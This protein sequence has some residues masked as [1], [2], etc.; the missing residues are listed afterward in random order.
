[1]AKQFNQKLKLLYLQRILLE[2]TDEQHPMT[3]P[4]LIGELLRYGIAAERKSVYA[5]LEALEQFG[6]DIA[7]EPGRNGGY[8][9]A[10]RLFEMPELK[11][12]VDAVQSSK[13][14]TVKKSNELIHKLEGFSSRYQAQQLQRQ[15]YVAN[16]VKSINE[17]V[18]YNIDR[19]HEGIA[20]NSRIS[21]QYYEY[22]V[23]KQRVY[24]RNGARYQVSPWAL[25]WDDENYYL[26][27]YDPAA[28]DIRHYRVDKMA[29]IELEEGPRDGQE[30]FEQLDMAVY[31]R[32]TFGMFGGEVCR[33]KL[34]FSNRL[35]GVVL[36]RFGKEVIIHKQD[37]TRFFVHTEVALS[38]LFF[39]WMM[40]FGDQAQILGPPPVVAQMRDILR[41]LDGL[42]QDWEGEHG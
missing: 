40:S 29:S 19:I 17:S 16:R 37:E 41:S 21:F 11:L 14:I 4:Q 12:L 25:S 32:R 15:V 30:V 9:V 6:L 10:Q 42:Y 33:V 39:S 3:V 8:Y 20:C 36:D 18:Y 35:I 5:D 22:N 26:I 38:P 23:D 7:R 34:A 1:M 24:R 13:F 27:A 28:A 2:Q 31:S